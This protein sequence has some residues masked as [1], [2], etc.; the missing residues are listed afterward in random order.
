MIHA[1]GKNN[2]VYEIQQATDLTWRIYDYERTDNQGQQRELHLAQA[3]DVLKN[4]SDDSIDASIK[5]VIS[6]T[7]TEDSFELNRYR[8][9]SVFSVSDCDV[10]ARNSCKNEYWLCTVTCGEGEMNGEKLR[11]E[12]ILSW[13]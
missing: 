5:Q 4:V 2:V 10:M 7:H 13:G 9:D 8:T 12:I 1:L 3:L 11:S 6:T